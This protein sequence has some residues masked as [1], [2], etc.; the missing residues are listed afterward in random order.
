MGKSKEILVAKFG[1]S[2][3]TNDTGIDK[4]RIEGYAKQLAQLKKDREIDNLVVVTSGAVVAGRVRYSEMHDYAS[5]VD[6]Q[7]LASLGSGAI[8]TAWGNAFEDQ[9]ILAGQLLVTHREIDSVEGDIL[10]GA[11]QKNAD[12]GVVT[13]TN[14]ND[15]LS[16]EE[17]K[18]LA[19]GGDNDGLASHIAK[20]IRANTLLLLTDVGGFKLNGEVQREIS[21]S[22]RETLL[23]QCDGIGKGKK[24][25]AGKVEAAIDAFQEPDGVRT[26][27]IG[28]AGGFYE[29][30]LSDIPDGRPG[31]R[32]VQ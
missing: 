32:V 23:S 11:L 24:G 17:L 16:D 10:A 30:M 15:L 25:M 4:F 19:Y 3:V 8:Y 29:D 14:E 5:S 1:S 28:H 2:I 26:V 12:E 18:K 22:E 31:T 27:H 20:R 21:A 6:E 13:V 9:G 7:V